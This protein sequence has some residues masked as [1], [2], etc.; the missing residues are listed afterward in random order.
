M[1][2][3]AYHFYRMLSE[4]REWQCFYCSL[5]SNNTPYII[6]FLFFEGK[7]C[8]FVQSADVLYEWDTC[9]QQ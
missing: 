6:F 7:R 8:R 1:D 9:C 4:K 2:L 3:L 5:F